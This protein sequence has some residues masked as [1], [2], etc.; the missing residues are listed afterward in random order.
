MK[1]P[2]PERLRRYSAALEKL[3][4]NVGKGDEVQF[5]RDLVKDLVFAAV[6]L[7]GNSD[8][9]GASVPEGPTL[10]TI[11][12]RN[13]VGFSLPYVVCADGTVWRALWNHGVMGG[14]DV[15]PRTQSLIAG[16][17]EE[18]PLPGSDRHVEI[19]VNVGDDDEL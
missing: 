19:F 15:D 17:K 16:W 18:L 6:A 3:I 10:E 5:F 8:S 14:P 7:E 11:Q 9:S 1:P 13:P 2:L 4:P 12:N